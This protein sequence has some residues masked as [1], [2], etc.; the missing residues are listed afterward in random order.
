MQTA[1]ATQCHASCLGLPAC[2]KAFQQHL[3]P[4]KTPS[5][6]PQPPTNP[7][8]NLSDPLTGIVDEN[9]DAC[10]GPAASHDARQRSHLC[11]LCEV[12]HCRTNQ[13][14]WGRG[15][16][17]TS[18]LAAAA[19]S[20]CHR[21][22][23]HSKSWPRP[24]THHAKH[25]R[26]VLTNRQELGRRHPCI[27]HRLLQLLQLSP[28]EGGRQGGGLSVA[29]RS[30]AAASSGGA[31]CPSN[32]LLPRRHYTGA[33]AAMMLRDAR[34]LLCIRMRCAAAWAPEH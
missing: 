12:T 34:L 26:H 27:Q 13:G 3:H 22:R 19:C 25:A 1:A 20:C 31:H 14:G 5:P 9:V 21:A 23:K 33:E 2:L 16:Q 6:H 7:Q 30:A 4:P 32:L 28:G 24:P 11:L 10:P 15:I 17:G 18:V 8:N 29:G